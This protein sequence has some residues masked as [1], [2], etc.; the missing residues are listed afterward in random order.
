M[1]RNWP[2]FLFILSALLCLQI[3]FCNQA[4]AMDVTNLSEM[5]LSLTSQILHSE[6]GAIEINMNDVLHAN[7]Y[8]R[9]ALSRLKEVS[10]PIGKKI[11]ENLFGMDWILLSDADEL[12]RPHGIGLILMSAMQ[13]GEMDEL[14]RAQ[15]FLRN[16]L[17]FEILRRNKVFNAQAEISI[18][19]LLSNLFLNP[20]NLPVIKNVLNG[21]LGFD[22]L[23]DNWIYEMRL[24]DVKTVSGG[25]MLARRNYRFIISFCREEFVF[26]IRER[27]SQRHDQYH[28]GQ[29]LLARLALSQKCEPIDRLL[30][31][32]NMRNIQ[33]LYDPPM[34]V[35]IGQVFKSI[36]TLDTY[37]KPIHTLEEEG[38]LGVMATSYK[39]FLKK[40]KYVAPEMNKNVGS[41]FNRIEVW[42]P[43]RSPNTKLK[44][45]GSSGELQSILVA[46]NSSEEFLKDLKL[47]LSLLIHSGYLETLQLM[48]EV[49]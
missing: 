5:D 48:S 32:L 36:F 37:L 38:I 18:E 8:L 41:D 27:E 4:L 49:P 24:S 46:P 12:R 28:G 17:K 29:A 6:N 2:L 43:N 31:T 26:P 33:P 3:A 44:A 11:E 40:E 21:P 14:K 20:K 25:V 9:S 35:M 10:N 22:K 42:N 15:F 23:N 16:G 7:S 13:Y 34:S 30:Y 47:G 19:I 45:L 1:R 39:K